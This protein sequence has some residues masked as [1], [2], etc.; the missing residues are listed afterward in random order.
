MATNRVFAIPLETFDA[1]TLTGGFDVAYDGIPRAIFL[2]RIINDSDQDVKV[3]YDGIDDHD[4]VIA[5]G[6][7]EINF[8]TNKQPRSHVALLPV[9]TKIYLHGPGQGGTGNIYISGYYV[10]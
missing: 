4:M 2:I 6:R 5:D 10:V 8:Q 9:G 1:G 7:L 3:S